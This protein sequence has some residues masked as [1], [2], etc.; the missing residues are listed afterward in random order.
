MIN[1][2]IIYGKKWLYFFDLL[3]IPIAVLFIKSENYYLTSLL[4]IVFSIFS[5]FLSFE[6]KDISTKKLVLISVLSAI[7]VAGRLIF[8]M[9]PQVKPMA[10][11]VII[12]GICLG[13][14]AGFITGA[15]SAFISNFFLGQ[16]I[17]T[18]W[19]MIA[20]GLLGFVAGIIFKFL[21]KKIGLICT[22][23]GI[24]VILIYGTIMN[25]SSFFLFNDTAS[26]SAL[27]AY[28]ASSL[29]MDIIHSLSTVVFLFLLYNPIQKQ[30]E[31]LLNK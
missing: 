9:V 26:L 13:A 17:W 24:S 1:F 25:F 2:S 12:S 11:L 29:P 30:I 16:G 22:S 23:A 5:L 20:F 28:T 18:P 27:L 31:R 4:I 14:E 3:L 7:S 21:P 19:Q 6:N 15:L 10:A 8:I